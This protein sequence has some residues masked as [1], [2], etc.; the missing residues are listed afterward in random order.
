[1][2]CIAIAAGG[3]CREAFPDRVAAG[4]SRWSSRDQPPDQRHVRMA[5]GHA[6]IGWIFPAGAATTYTAGMFSRIFA[7]TARNPPWLLGGA[8]AF[9]I[10]LL[11]A[12]LLAATVAALRFGV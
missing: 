9:A 8:V 12:N 1:M 4:R 7:G 11:W 3:G 6:S 10:L 2:D 5:S